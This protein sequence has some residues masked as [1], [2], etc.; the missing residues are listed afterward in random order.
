MSARRAP[1]VAGT[2]HKPVATREQAEAEV[3]GWSQLASH[4]V[5][6]GLHGQ[7]AL[8]DRQLL[9]YEDVFATGR[10]VL[11]MG[12][13]I[14]LADRDPAMQP[15][16]DCLVDSV[17]ADLR[18]AAEETGERVPLAECVPDLYLD[19]IRPGGRLDRW[20][21]RRDLP[22]ALPHI[23]TT[24]TLREL[25]GFTLTANGRQLTLNVADTIDSL[26]HVLAP[27][28][29]W[30]AGLSQGDPT[31]PNI[32]DP[33][34]WLDFE[35]AGRNTVVGEA[36]NLLWYLMA[37]GGWL[38]PHYQPD[39]YSRTL[40]LALPPLSRPRIEYL[41]LHEGSRHI[42][43]RY[44][45]NTGPGRSAAVARALDGLRGGDGSGLEEIHAFLAMRILGVIP[46]SRLTGHDL[47]LVLIKLAES[48][49]PL[50]TIDT[51]FTTT[52]APHPH[53]GER[54]SHVPA[55]A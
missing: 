54:S 16:L 52:P 9:A 30:L 5:V 48:Q 13:V 39:V 42:D 20:Y 51:F 12:D 34:C 31:E 32:A 10:C 8:P 18:A 29:R 46:T 40:R 45:W 47:L 53:S 38:V 4:I 24:L 3:R 55:P 25:A 44:S 50:T 28:R 35:F 23:G 19:R 49:E 36:A 7:V 21:L 27:D 22:I 33:L 2:F 15:R 41:D 1:A 14:A 6:P 37:L 11:L 26:R 17:C 43:V